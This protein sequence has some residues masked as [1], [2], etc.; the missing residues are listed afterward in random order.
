VP[1]AYVSLIDGDQQWA[2]A[3]L[4]Y[5]LEETP[6]DATFC[7]HA[8]L[9]R[10]VLAVPDARVD[11]RFADNPLVFDGPRIRF[12]AGAPPTTRDGHAIGALCVVDSQRREIGV[13]QLAC[14]LGAGRLAALCRQIEHEAR[15]GSTT[16]S[17]ALLPVLEAEARRVRSA[18]EEAC[19]GRS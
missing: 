10:D 7:G 8:I 17:A 19:P 13:G 12:Y 11:V 15:Q 4:G 14:L 5:K 6:R 1:I 9:S 3:T 2:K 16:E 18:L